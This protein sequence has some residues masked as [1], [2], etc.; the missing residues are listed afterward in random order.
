MVAILV[1]TEATG[2]AH[3]F[4]NEVQHVSSRK[5]TMQVGLADY[6]PIG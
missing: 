3:D 4:K 5:Y 2:A 1:P 6:Y